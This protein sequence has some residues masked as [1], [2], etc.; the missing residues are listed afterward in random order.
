MFT[1][2]KCCIEEEKTLHSFH[3]TSTR[4]R[5]VVCKQTAHSHIHTPVDLLSVY[6]SRLSRTTLSVQLLLPSGTSLLRLM[7]ETRNCITLA[8]HMRLNLRPS[9]VKYITRMQFFSA[10]PWQKVTAKR[11]NVI[12]G[13]RLARVFTSWLCNNE[14]RN[15]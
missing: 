7:A 15:G 12:L 6:M 4:M 14:L 3:F 10:S 11:Y 2:T 1:N 13:I 5:F 9:R 8:A